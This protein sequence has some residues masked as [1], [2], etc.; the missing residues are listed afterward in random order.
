MSWTCEKGSQLNVLLC[1]MHIMQLLC[2]HK[3]QTIKK[4]FGVSIAIL[5]G[6]ANSGQTFI[7]YRNLACDAEPLPAKDRKDFKM[8]LEVKCLYHMYY[9]VIDVY[10]SVLNFCE[11][12]YCL[13]RLRHTIPL[14]F[15]FIFYHTAWNTT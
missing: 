12:T 14:R 4:N 3:A 2:V 1:P 15:S 13:I 7:N 11:I 5:I 6:G 8:K 10:L 9:I